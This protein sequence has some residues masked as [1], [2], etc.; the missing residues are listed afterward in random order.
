MKKLSCI[1]CGKYRRCKNSK[2]SYILG[3]TLVLSIIYSK[4]GNEDEKIFKE[5]G[6]IQILELLIYLKT[7]NYF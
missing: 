3:K 4:C 7:Y 6:S 5:E 2:M 1:F